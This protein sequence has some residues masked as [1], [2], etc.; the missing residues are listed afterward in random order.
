MKFDIEV[1][2]AINYVYI[3]AVINGERIGKVCI[4]LDSD[5]MVRYMK[6]HK[7]RFAKVII[8]ETSAKYCR[9]GIATALLNK[10]IEVMKDYNLYLN[11]IPLKRNEDDMD[12]N[13]LIA[14]YSKFGFKRY[15]DDICVVTMVRIS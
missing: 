6:L 14:F 5:D 2:W 1:S 10:T 13:Q 3:N 11:V 7:G 9:Q 4:D 8:V 15:E 12:R